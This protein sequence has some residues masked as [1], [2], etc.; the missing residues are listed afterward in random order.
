MDDHEREDD[1]A[2]PDWGIPLSSD[3][4]LRWAKTDNGVALPSGRNLPPLDPI[5]KAVILYFTFFAWVA[6]HANLD[7]TESIALVLSAHYPASE[8]LEEVYNLHV[9]PDS[10]Q[11]YFGHVTTYA[12]NAGY[13]WDNQ[14]IVAEIMSRLVKD[15]KTFDAVVSVLVNH[16]NV[17]RF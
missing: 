9:P 8:I 16:R 15:L 5:H 6:S 7:D 13:K 2:L 11:A 4:D 10:I 1:G 12:K 14:K 17:S 3:R